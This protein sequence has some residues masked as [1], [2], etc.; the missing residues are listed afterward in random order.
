MSLLPSC[1]SLVVKASLGTRPKGREYQ[2]AVCFFDSVTMYP[3]DSVFLLT[4]SKP[5][6]FRAEATQLQQEHFGSTVM[7]VEFTL[8][9]QTTFLNY[10]LFTIYYQLFTMP[11]R[12]FTIYYLLSTIYY[13]LCLS[14]IPNGARG[15]TRTRTS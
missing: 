5:T 8:S 2:A 3:S 13:V 15:G 14:G 12:H 4:F 7:S 10:L 1:L 9:Q 6:K 11:F